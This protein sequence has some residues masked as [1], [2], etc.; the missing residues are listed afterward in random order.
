MARELAALTFSLMLVSA[1]ARADEDASTP[2]PVVVGA[3]NGIGSSYGMFGASVELYALRGYLATV[4]GVGR[5]PAIEGDERPGLWAF[6]GGIRGF[7]PGNKHRA[8]AQLSAS[9]LSVGW[10]SWGGEIIEV[11]KYYG[12]TIT[13]G[14]QLVSYGGFTFLAG[15]GAGWAPG[16]EDWGV[17]FDLGFGFTLRAW[18]REEGGSGPLGAPPAVLEDR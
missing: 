9:L 4:V 3:S 18:S 15:L 12:P 13:G 1:P 14:Y 11:E 10:L 2:P 17:V 16:T 8:Y 5:W 7:S 6:S